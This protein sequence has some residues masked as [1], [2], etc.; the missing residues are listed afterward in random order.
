ARAGTPPPP[1]PAGGAPR[2]R[3]SR[4]RSPPSTPAAW[5]RHG[6]TAPRRQLDRLVQSLD[7]MVQTSRTAT[8]GVLLAAPLWGV[9][10][11]FSKV[12]IAQLT[13][14]DLFA[15]EVST[16]ALFLGIAAV[17]RGARPRR[18]SAP[19]LLLGVLEPGLA[20]LLFDIGIAHTAATDGAL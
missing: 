3:A 13:P 14:V 6:R 11:A 16:G 12:A 10:T 19:V 8:A 5:P 17:A 15:I 20:F 1:R 2:R 7:R 4:V 9:S 18:P